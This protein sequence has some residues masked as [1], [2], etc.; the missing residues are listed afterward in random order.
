MD[1][2]TLIRFGP[3]AANGLRE[4]LTDLSATLDVFRRLRDMRPPVDD[5]AALTAPLYAE[6]LYNLTVLAS[7]HR[8]RPPQSLTREDIWT[9]SRA[10]PEILRRL[11]PTDATVVAAAY[12]HLANV[13]LLLNKPPLLLVYARFS[14][15]DVRILEGARGLFVQAELVLRKCTFD[16]A[17]QSQ[18]ERAIEDA[19]LLRP[20][21]S[22]DT[23]SGLR[24]SAE[25]LITDYRT[26]G[27][28]ALVVIPNSSLWS[29]AWRFLWPPDS[30][31][32]PSE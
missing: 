27:L 8:L 21:K 23:L 14:G 17:T 19:G 11:S 30:G 31:H 16:T 15:A 24:D 26:V 9:D 25:C 13:R 6:T 4:V 10:Q 32:A 2:G 29:R 18:L 1:I 7:A 28:I 20:L 12:E 5:R 22:K 3:A